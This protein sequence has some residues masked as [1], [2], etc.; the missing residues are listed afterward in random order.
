M[1]PAQFIP[2]TWK[3]YADRIAELTGH[4]PAS[5]WNN[6]DAIMGTALYIKDAVSSCDNTY[7]KLGDIERC[8][9]ARYYAG[10][11]WRRH[12]WGYGDRVETKA[13]QF[14][15]DIDVLNS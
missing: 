1:G 4:N 10:S 5:P 11:R 6:G 12:F 15:Q 2:S 8:A 14:Q 13:N 7:T 9:A 3:L